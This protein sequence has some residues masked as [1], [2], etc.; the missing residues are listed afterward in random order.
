MFKKYVH[1]KISNFKNILLQKCIAQMNPSIISR[2][3]F[4]L[5]FEKILILEVFILGRFEVK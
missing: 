3:K 2:C 1:E 5:K 4:L